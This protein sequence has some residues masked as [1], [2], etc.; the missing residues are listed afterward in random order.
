MWYRASRNFLFFYSARISAKNLDWLCR[1]THAASA[2]CA[3][4]PGYL[5]EANDGHCKRC[6]AIQN[7]VP[8]LEMP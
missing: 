2:L 6:E 8:F 5:G 1:D 7:D 3:S 4:Q